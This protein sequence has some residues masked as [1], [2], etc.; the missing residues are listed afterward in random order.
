MMQVIHEDIKIIQMNMVE[1]LN[2]FHFTS[3]CLPQK[4]CMSYFMSLI[5]SSS[6]LFMG[7]FPFILYLFLCFLTYY[8][9]VFR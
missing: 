9:I 8:D 6:K 7:H 1:D 2:D 5:H 3:L 4:N